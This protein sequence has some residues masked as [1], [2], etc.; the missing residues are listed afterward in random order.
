MITVPDCEITFEI[1]R[2]VLSDWKKELGKSVFNEIYEA[3]QYDMP[4]MFSSFEDFGSKLKTLKEYIDKYEENKTDEKLIDTN[5]TEK[6]MGMF[7]Q[8]E[9]SYLEIDG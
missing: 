9:I 5:D 4:E 1:Y 8:E 7:G 2:S 3:A 6:P